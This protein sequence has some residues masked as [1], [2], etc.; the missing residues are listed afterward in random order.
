MRNLRTQVASVLTIPFLYAG[1]AQ[2]E[3]VPAKRHVLHAY[4]APKFE[5]ELYTKGLSYIQSDR[6]DIYDKI[7]TL[8]AVTSNLLENGS[9]V[10]PEIVTAVNEEFWNLL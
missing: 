3:L 5:W 10:D 8:H 2:A 4:V 6:D 7:A 9:N 1:T